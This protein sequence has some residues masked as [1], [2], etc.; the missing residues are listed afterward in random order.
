MCKYAKNVP[1]KREKSAETIAYS[2]LL[3]RAIIGLQKPKCF[4]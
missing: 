4:S 1:K 3:S 2:T